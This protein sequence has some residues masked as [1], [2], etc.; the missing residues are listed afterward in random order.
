[1]TA[2]VAGDDGGVVQ[3]AFLHV[4]PRVG[5]MVGQVAQLS[6]AIG[7]PLDP[8]QRLAVDVLTSLRADG[9]PASLESAVITCRQN[10]KTF[11]AERVVLTYMVE[12]DRPGMQPTR[13]AV[14]SAHEFRTAQESFRHFDEVVAGFS[15][16]SRRVLKVSRANGEE[17]FEFR[18]GKRLMFRARVRTG[19]RGLTGD[20]IVLDEAFALQPAHLGSLLPTLSTRRRAKVLYCSSAGL[21]ASQILRGV[22]DRGRAG[23]RGAPAYVEWCAPGSLAEPGC[24]REKCQHV[25]ATP[26]CALD[27]EE[28]W[29][30]ANPAIGRRIDIEFVRAERLALPPE[31]FARERLGWWDDPDEAARP[32]KL[33]DWA[34]CARDV[35]PAGVPVFFLDCSPAMTSATIAVAALNDGRPHVELA[36]YR[37]GT[38]WLVE[39]AGELRSQHLDAVFAVQANGAVTALLPKLH[40]V[41]VRPKQLT[42]A[43]MGRACAH[44]QA[45]VPEGLTHSDD[46]AVALALAGAVPRDIGDNLWT[47]GRRRSAADISPIVAETGALFALELYGQDYD[48]SDSFG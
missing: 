32:I 25:P 38:D 42:Q 27:R 22:R 44:L 26:G 23:G 6:D 2:A 15:F 46:E 8:E 47:W 43:D 40:E 5:S 28:F 9:R 20:V 35:Q 19:G 10:L 34:A 48:L 13:L 14:W 41:D 30:A 39:R 33:D 21:A 17:E 36:D 4:P 3:P 45:L 29:R 7:T 18:G 11:C 1:M 37:S 24:G 16:L 31:E 12:P